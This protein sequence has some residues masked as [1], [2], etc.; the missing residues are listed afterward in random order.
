VRLYGQSSTF[1]RDYA[2]PIRIAGFAR[3]TLYTTPESGSAFIY[4]AALD[5]YDQ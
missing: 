4:R 1:S 2:T 5:Y 3:I